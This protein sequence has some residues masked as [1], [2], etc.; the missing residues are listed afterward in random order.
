M[1]TQFNGFRAQV[2]KGL[3]S[4]M[5]ISLLIMLQL[6]TNAF[7]TISFNDMEHDGLN[8][9][10]IAPSPAVD[11]VSVEIQ[12][13]LENSSDI[14]LFTTKGQIVLEGKIALLKG[15]NQFKIDISDLPEGRYHMH[16]SNDKKVDFEGDK[17]VVKVI[18]L[19]E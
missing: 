7:D 18:A 13:A 10:F 11:F 17:S 5:V 19:K 6:S 15:Y 1:R 4:I 2:Y 16:L 14:V 9:I 3:K 12:S 8:H